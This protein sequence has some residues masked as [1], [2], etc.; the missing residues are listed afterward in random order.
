PKKVPALRV[1]TPEKDLRNRSDDVLTDR[2]HFG[3]LDP[4]VVVGK[5]VD[6]DQPLRV[7]RE[8]IDENVESAPLANHQTLPVPVDHGGKILASALG[9]IGRNIRAD[10]SIVSV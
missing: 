5:E 8:R 6:P 3:M 9:Q 1:P 7:P 4:D 10:L 2:E